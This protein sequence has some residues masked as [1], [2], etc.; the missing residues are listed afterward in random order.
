[1]IPNTLGQIFTWLF[2][3][4]SGIFGF[5]ITPS[6]AHI[7]GYL[8]PFRNTTQARTTVSDV[9][10]P[11]STAGEACLDYGNCMPGLICC[12]VGDGNKCWECCEDVHCEM[13]EMTKVCWY[14]KYY[15][16]LLSLISTQ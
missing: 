13:L 16:K 3:I 6:F 14:R 5:S 15:I 2:V 7:H 12:N 1:M 4:F 11:I 10:P 8:G 9:V